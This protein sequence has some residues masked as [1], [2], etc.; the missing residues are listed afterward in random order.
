MTRYSVF[1]ALDSGPGQYLE[2][3][4]LVEASD[5]RT[6]AQKV[7]D[8]GAMDLGEQFPLMLIIEERAASLFTRDQRGQAVTP[9]EDIHRQLKDRQHVP[10]FRLLADDESP[11]T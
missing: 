2:L 3:D 9:V 7:I 8:R 10:R 4:D 1:L 5:P 6:A 11:S